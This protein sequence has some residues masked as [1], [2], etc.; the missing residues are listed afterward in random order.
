MVEKKSM[1]NVS[2]VEKGRG[3]AFLGSTGDHLL[4]LERKIGKTAKRSIAVAGLAVLLL[5]TGMLRGGY[6]PGAFG[7]EDSSASTKTSLKTKGAAKG[8]MKD[9]ESRKYDI[10][11]TLAINN[12]NYSSDV[13][14]CIVRIPATKEFGQAFLLN[15]VT[16]KGYWYQVGISQGFYLETFNDDKFSIAYQVSD[17]EG[18]LLHTTIQLRNSIEPNKDYVIAMRIEDRYAIASVSDASGNMIKK[19]I[20]PA[21]G[22]SRFVG[23]QWNLKNGSIYFTGPMTEISSVNETVKANSITYILTSPMP[24]NGADYILVSNIANSLRL[25][26]SVVPSV[27]YVSGSLFFMG[28]NKTELKMRN[29][30]ESLTSTEVEIDGKKTKGYAFTTS[31]LGK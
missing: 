12:A 29:Y 8:S 28:D 6:P 16:D 20:G 27:T 21:F 7:A 26:V 17:P 10:Q 19:I 9:L 24:V 18:K 23:E 11:Q 14:G 2:Y 3:L 4:K 22:S 5:P 31:S 13:I 15:G 30:V 25:G 1:G